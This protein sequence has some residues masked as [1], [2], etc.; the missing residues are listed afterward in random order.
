MRARSAAL[1]S[2]FVCSSACMIASCGNTGGGRDVGGRVTPDADH[3][4]MDVFAFPV[5]SC[6]DGLDCTEFRDYTREE[7][8]TFGPACMGTWTIDDE[9]ACDYRDVVGGCRDFDP[10]GL[11]YRVLWL[12][13]PAYDESGAR[14]LCDTARLEFVPPPE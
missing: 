4:H 5:G 11:G 8:E 13:T 3:A 7:L 1:L 2:F 12:R 9:P 14:T 10:D 6:L